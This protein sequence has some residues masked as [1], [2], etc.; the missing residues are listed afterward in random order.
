MS[1]YG[2]PARMTAGD[3]DSVYD[4]S[5]PLYYARPNDP[6]FPLHCTESSSGTCPIEGTK[7]RI[8]ARRKARR[9][10]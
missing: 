4:W 1:L 3:A 6:V 8:P 7:A 5:H 9:G 10:Q 2:G